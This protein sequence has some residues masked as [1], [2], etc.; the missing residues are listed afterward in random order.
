MKL[1]DVREAAQMLAVSPWTVRAY[2]REGKLCPIRMGRLIRLDG[3]EL[4][5]FVVSPKVVSNGKQIGGP[6]NKACL[7]Q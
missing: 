5:R 4:E 1:Y 6:G 2:F 7:T 3:Q